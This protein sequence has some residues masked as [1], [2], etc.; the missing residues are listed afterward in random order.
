MMGPASKPWMCPSTEGELGVRLSWQRTLVASPFV[1]GSFPLILPTDTSM[2][3]QSELP[4]Y[5]IVQQKCGICH[6]ADYVSYQTPGMSQAQ[7][8]AEMTKMQHSYGAPINE[9]EI[10]LIGAYLAVTY[11]SASKEDASV[12][13]LS[14]LLEADE[15]GLDGE[16]T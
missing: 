16:V 3:R 8:N 12:V 15:P 6:S 1:D 7:W 10:K 13:A 4:G 2:L 9:D 5:A 14:A 11:G